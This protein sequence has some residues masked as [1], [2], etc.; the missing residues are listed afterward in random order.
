MTINWFDFSKGGV[1]LIV[2]L[3]LSFIGVA[4]FFERLFYF[5]LVRHRVR[6]AYPELRK[7]MIQ[8]R[9]VAISQWCAT[10]SDPLSNVILKIVRTKEL[11]ISGEMKIDIV[12]IVD[13]EVSKLSLNLRSI[14]S[15]ASISPLLGL[16]GT[17]V[18]MI[19]IFNAIQFK[20]GLRYQTELA[21]GIGKALTTTVAGL[22]VAIALTICF[23]I[24]REFEDR[25]A[26]EIYSYSYE[27][28][29]LLRGVRVE[30]KGIKSIVREDANV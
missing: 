3:I 28:I 12:P 27:L 19:Q 23:N 7:M 26:D 30:K 1:I 20:G 17:V 8:R 24:L 2:I 10:H 5:L 29:S 22:V 16:L 4:L 9:F 13:G 6:K 18:G 25:I 11:T 15:I 21:G 14:S